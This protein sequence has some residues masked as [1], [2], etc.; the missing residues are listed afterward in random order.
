MRK[1][2][3]LLLVASAGLLVAADAPEEAVK[4]E[5]DK[6]KGT[7]T[8]TLYEANGQKPFGED[9][10]QSVIMTFDP[11]GNFKIDAGGMTIEA[12]TKIDPTKHPKTID[13]TFTDGQLKGKTGLG[14]YELSDDTLKLCRAAPDKSRPSEFSAKA[15]SELTLTAYKRAKP[16]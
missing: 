10:L 3:L 14:I 1:M 6:L 7:W 9:M 2:A 13:F 8:M 11:N 5:R 16:K 4:K 12:K 15:G